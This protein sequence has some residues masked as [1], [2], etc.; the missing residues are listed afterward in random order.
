[1]IEK[2]ENKTKE[3]SMGVEGANLGDQ[4]HDGT[5]DEAMHEEFNGVEDY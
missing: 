1:M 3:E 5:M 4:N 2:L